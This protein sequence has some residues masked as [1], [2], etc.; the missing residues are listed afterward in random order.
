MTTRKKTPTAKAKPKAATRSK[1]TSQ[2]SVTVVSFEGVTDRALTALAGKLA[3]TTE[4]YAVESALEKVV[5]APVHPLA[6]HLTT[7]RMVAAERNIGLLGVLADDPTHAPP[8]AVIDLLSRV[9]GDAD[10][11]YGPEARLL[12]GFPLVLDTL[13]IE[14]Y[15]RAP[16]LFRAR[17]KMLPEPVRLG[18]AMVQRR[19]GEDIAADDARAILTAL[20]KLQAT[21]HELALNTELTMM[22]DGQPVAFRLA[23]AVA[24]REL[25]L[26]F[27]SR[28]A[29]NHALLAELRSSKWDGAV[30][31]VLD[32][33]R[34]ATPVEL[35]KMV[36]ATSFAHDSTLGLFVTLL[37]ERADP[38]AALLAAAR[39]IKAGADDRHAR[40]MRELFALY[41]AIRFA[42]Q[43]EPIPPNLD[44]LIQFE[45]ASGVYTSS[46]APTLAAA[47]ALG[48]ERTHALVRRALTSPYNY[49]NSAVA[50]AAYFDAELFG[51]LV[52][53]NYDF[54]WLPPKLVGPIGEPALEPLANTL[55]KLAPN[56]RATRGETILECLATTCETGVPDEKWDAYVTFDR[57]SWSNEDAALRDRILNKLP[58]ERREKLLLAHIARDEHPA[59]AFNVAPRD[60]S[61]AFVD[62]AVRTIVERHDRF[63]HLGE[64]LRRLGARAADALCRH[65]ALCKG[66]GEFLRHL[67]MLL[68]NEYPRI[69][70]ALGGTRETPLESLRRLLASASGPKQRV[71]LLE[72]DR[73]SFTPKQGSLSRSGGRP[74]G[75]RPDAV[76]TAEDGEAMQHLLT[77]DL[78]E[79]P[80][81]QRWYPDARALAYFYPEPRLGRRY[82][83]AKLVAIPRAAAAAQPNRGEDERPIAVVGIDVPSACFDRTNDRTLASIRAAIF[84]AA[85][86]VLGLPLW[87]QGEDEEVSGEFVLQVNPGLAD[88]NLGD[89]GSLYVFT[90][91]TAFQCH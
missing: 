55:E 13:V 28:D 81:L 39:S 58:H 41:A 87:I 32:A 5:P 43:R 12:P 62:A 7:H 83:E 31:P 21:T 67:E 64:G 50:L 38:G 20:A 73:E 22:R 1:P 25:A 79:L 2:P 15:Q 80:E 48:R 18:L 54:D 3:K 89:L 71:Y 35:A 78:E 44:S 77:L 65:I 47:R 40:E 51:E 11:V 26:L 49:G 34:I 45:F 46:I 9:P 66:D 30:E 76:P 10:D 86:Q 24:V 84:G 61:D 60:A 53:K 23:N 75:L 85:G 16:E 8:E 91:G 74:P 17:A 59:R 27:G 56:Y 33:L 90:E 4:R 88:V 52:N 42:A 37:D 68:P 29:W 36:S 57:Q 82:A 63:E 14:N 6:W 19:L 70:A 69:A 72:V